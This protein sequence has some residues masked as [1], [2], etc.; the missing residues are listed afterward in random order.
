M[1]KRQAQEFDSL[2]GFTGPAPRV[3]PWRRTSGM[4][5]IRRR[6]GVAVVRELWYVR[7]RIAQRRDVSP[8]RVLS[9]AALVA[10]AVLTHC[11]DDRLPGRVCDPDPG[12]PRWPVDSYLGI[13]AHGP[14][15][16][17]ANLPG[18]AWWPRPEKPSNHLERRP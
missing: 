6:R 4:H 16:V 17:R 5:K 2:L 8:G 15:P 18:M 7:D 1:Y 13:P 9:D 14:K 3:D 10:L 11:S 12:S